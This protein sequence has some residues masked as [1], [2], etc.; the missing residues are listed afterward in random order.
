MFFNINQKQKGGEKRS[1]SSSRRVTWVRSYLKTK[2][3]EM[4]TKMFAVFALVIAILA[5]S[6]TTK[7]VYPEVITVQAECPEVVVQIEPLVC[8]EAVAV[9]EEPVCSKL[10]C[11]P[12]IAVISAFGGEN[13]L[14]LAELE[15]T[16]VIPVAMGKGTV[17]F[18][19][20]TLRDK[21]VAV[22]VTETSMIN[23]ASITTMA[24]EKF[25]I[26]AIVF[27]GISGGVDPE[28]N[29]GDVVIPEKWI[30]YQ[31]NY[32]CQEVNGEFVCPAWFAPEYPAF[33]MDQVAP[34]SLPGG[35]S[36]Y[37]FNVDP[38]L[39]AAAQK[40]LTTTL[41]SCDINN[42]CLT[43][44][45][46][47]VVGG[48]GGSAQSFVDNAEYRD[49]LFETFGMRVLEMEGAAV[50]HVAYLYNTPF[51]V[52]RANSDLAGGGDPEDKL[53]DGGNPIDVF[54]Q[55]AAQNAAKVTL[56]LVEA[57]NP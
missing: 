20:G 11:S 46:K 57:Y 8:S 40:T 15:E 25:N 53:P 47:V 39:F 42:V 32:K 50:A 27:T 13:D 29:I 22:F 56:D 45:A 30:E 14:V 6:C 10:D 23:A 55:I 2:E 26:T 16:N 12:R 4:K 31:E 52:I 21:N 51:V 1:V 41:E 44:S 7:T 9:E 54:W 17:D 28:V 38:S 49:Y 35:E 24:L 19:L 43:K 37:W 18:H 33:G 48:A 34:A 5:T 36:T 3:F